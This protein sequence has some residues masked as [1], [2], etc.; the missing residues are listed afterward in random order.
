MGC[1][2][3]VPCRTIKALVKAAKL[4]VI[5][6]MITQMPVLAGGGEYD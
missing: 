5:D 4:M 1:K 2:G 6:A 3:A